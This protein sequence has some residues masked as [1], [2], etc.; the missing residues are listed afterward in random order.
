MRG[1]LPIVAYRL[2]DMEPAGPVP[3]RPSVG[4][5]GPVTLPLRF[6]ASAMI[7]S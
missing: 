3:S 5:I 7:H 2:G 1:A 4:I 6:A